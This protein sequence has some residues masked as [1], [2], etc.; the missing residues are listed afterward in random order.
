MRQARQTKAQAEQA[1]AR[2][3]AEQCH[4][5]LTAL[6][7]SNGCVVL[8]RDGGVALRGGD[9]STAARLRPLRDDVLAWLRRHYAAHYRFTEPVEHTVFVQRAAL[10]F[11]GVA[12]HSNE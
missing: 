5:A 2:H 6:N 10:L 11:G 9:A 12:H 4:A 7:A 1:V 3:R 8:Q